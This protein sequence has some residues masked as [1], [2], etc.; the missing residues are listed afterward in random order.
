MAMIKVMQLNTNRRRDS[1]SLLLATAVQMCVDVVIVSEPPKVLGGSHKWFVDCLGNSAIGVLNKKC[2]VYNTYLG[3]FFVALELEAFTI[4]GC[5]FPPSLNEEG[6][7]K[8]MCI[9]ESHMKSNNKK[10]IIAGD[11]NAASKIWGSARQDRRGTILLEFMAQHDLL[12]LNDGVSPTFDNGR[13]TSFVDLTLVSSTIGNLCEKWHVMGEEMLSDHR[14]ITFQIVGCSEKPLPTKTTGWALKKINVNKFKESLVEESNRADSANAD[15]LQKIVTNAC[16]TS[17]PK[18]SRRRGKPPVYWWTETIAAHRKECIR[19]R[20]NIRKLNRGHASQAALDEIINMYRESK[21]NLRNEIFRS[22]KRCWRSLC[23]KL[24]EDVWGDGYRIVTRELKL[25]GPMTAI[26]AATVE[27]II[28]ALFPVGEEVVWQDLPIED[29]EVKPFTE[30]ELKDAVGR[31]KMRKAAGPDDI[32]PEIVRLTANAIPGFLL[33]VMNFHLAAGDF[34]TTWKISRLV[35]LPKPGKNIS[36]PSGY[37]PLCIL[38]VFGKLLE[39]LLLARLKECVNERNAISQAQFGFREGRSTVDA[40]ARV[41]GSAEESRRKSYRHRDLCLLVTIDIRNAFNSASWQKVL[42]TLRKRGIAEYIIRMIRSYLHQRSIRITCGS[43]IKWFEISSGVPQG[44]VLGPT[45]WNLLFDG[46]LRIAV[47]DGVRLTAYADDLAIVIRAKTEKE[48]VRKANLVISYV[49]T[50]MKAHYLQV[51]P[52]K[53]EAVWLAARRKMGNIAIKIGDVVIAPSNAVKYLGIYLDR[54][55]TFKFHLEMTIQKARKVI[56][57]L[58]RLMPSMG[59]PRSRIRRVLASVACSI[60]LYGA[61]VWADVLKQKK[62]QSKATSLYRELAIRV[63]SAYRTISGEAVQVIAKMAPIEL[64]VAERRQRYNG[65]KEQNAKDKLLDAWQESWFASTKGAWTKRL[66]PQ[67]KPWMEC[68]HNEV[69]YHL[70]Q[71]LSGHGC[72]REYLFKK[73]RAANPHCPYDEEVDDVE[74]TIF[75][76]ERWNENRA[77]CEKE[78]KLRLTPG[79]VV[80]VMMESEERWGLVKEMVKDIIS[81]KEAEEKKIFTKD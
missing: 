54:G 69:D 62:F 22:K 25:N 66:I 5:Y 65:A 33:D 72:F 19:H 29:Q 6:F 16:D 63:V 55:L 80:D 46:V 15:T 81:A 68:S 31:M 52:E 50:W 24:D 75:K 12:A 74:H 40:I 70:C 26:P 9:M 49:E 4:Y 73:K 42:D 36:D 37:R 76:C 58:S 21:K 30:A 27:Q 77:K 41:V 59:G 39:Y 78:L 51:A 11:L 79:N 71:F 34:P 14:C 47:P 32:P 60:I 64:I 61:P 45:L 18:L 44:S 53:T 38:N 57:A 48:I 8:E 7:V 10:V 13:Y 2:V 56:N 23:D 20:R 35:L 67:I 28:R 3:H 1:L 17:M 43:E